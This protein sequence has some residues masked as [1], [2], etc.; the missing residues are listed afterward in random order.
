MSLTEKLID[1]IS[2]IADWWEK[3]ECFN[4]EI[5]IQDDVIVQFVLNKSI[6]TLSISRQKEIEISYNY[7][8]EKCWFF[9]AIK[10]YVEITANR[11]F[12]V[13]CVLMFVNFQKF[14]V[15]YICAV[16]F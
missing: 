8:V 5:I 10:D 7:D 14:I 16:L 2:L 15:L 11:A 4:L 12:I 13:K 6:K 9:S 1:I 3:T